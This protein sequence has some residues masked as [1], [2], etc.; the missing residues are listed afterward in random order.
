MR[1]KHIADRR[2]PGPLPG[3]P[4]ERYQVLLPLDLAEW[5]KRRPGGLSKLVRELL[6]REYYAQT[7]GSES[8]KPTCN[9]TLGQRLREIREEGIA[10]GEVKL[11][12]WDEIEAEMDE[13]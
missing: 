5:G 7:T 3:P 12:S 6:S 2:R 11:M 10:A 9:K 13:S 8:S 4:T 1:M